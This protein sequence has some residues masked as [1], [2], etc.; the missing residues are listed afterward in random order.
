MKLPLIPPT[1]IVGVGLNY[2]RH[3]E[4]LGMRLPSQP[5]V[6]LK[7]R[8]S[9]IFHGQD[10]IIKKEWG[11][12]DYEGELAVVMG[13]KAWNIRPEEAH[14]YILGYTC[15]NDVTA[16]DFQKK[17]G[18]WARA[19][20]LPTFSVVG[21]HIVTKDEVGDPHCLKIEVRV[22]GEVKQLSSTSDLIFSVYELV[23]FVSSFVVLSPGDIIATGTPPGVGPLRPGDVVEVEIEKIGIL[24]NKVRL[25][26]DGE[27]PPQPA[28]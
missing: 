8:A 3:A 2:R 19:K 12:I 25:Y 15:F 13:K 27:V 10:I 16:R 18:Q 7:D 22:N 14:D 28:V 23:S 9:L 5:I 21:P 4:E 26:K 17:D 11:R 6:F 20:S 1:R 24:K